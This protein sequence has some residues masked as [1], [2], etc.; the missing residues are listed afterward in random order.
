MRGKTW[1]GGF[2]RGCLGGGWSMLTVCFCLLFASYA[3]CYFYGLFDFY[4]FSCG[5]C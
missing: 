5:W 2:F 3:C 4:C 1:F